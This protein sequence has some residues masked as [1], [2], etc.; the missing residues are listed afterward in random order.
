M[1]DETNKKSRVRKRRV[2]PLVAIGIIAGTMAVVIGSLKPPCA[3]GDTDKARNAGVMS[4]LNTI[5][6]GLEQYASDHDGRY[7]TDSEFLK[8]LT[9]KDY[10]PKNRL[11]RS[12][13]AGAQVGQSNFIPIETWPSPLASAFAQ[14]ER[15]ASPVFLGE[16]KVPV[17]SH[18]DG[19][20][21]GAVFYHYD[22]QRQD[23]LLAGVGKEKSGSKRAILIQP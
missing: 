9:Q 12:P 17:T 13:W 3:C 16:G 8:A 5:R 18:Y 14:K 7:P 19:L 2:H 11:P 23:Y 21:Y 22:A 15:P 20:T 1:G 4:N 10:L 6:F